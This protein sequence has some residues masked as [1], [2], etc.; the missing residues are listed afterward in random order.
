[1]KFLSFSNRRFQP[2][3]PTPAAHLSDGH[4]ARA[5]GF[6]SAQ[7]PLLNKRNDTSK[8]SAVFETKSAYAI[9][10]RA[11]ELIPPVWPPGG[12]QTRR[13]LMFTCRRIARPFSCT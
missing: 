9:G 6:N 12:P 8:A 3:D 2:A 13:S 1:M 10:E 11:A 4:L 7:N 5:L